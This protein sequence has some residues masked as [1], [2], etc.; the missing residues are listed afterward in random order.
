MQPRTDLDSHF[1]KSVQEQV[2]S[3]KE[4]NL[5]DATLNMAKGYL[6]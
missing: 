4:I 6:Q 3:L 5:E 2:Y 1:L